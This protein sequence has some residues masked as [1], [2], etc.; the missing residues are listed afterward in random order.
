MAR[1]IL[2]TLGSLGDLHPI[3]ALALELRRRGHEAVV[4]TSE[5]Y[6]EKIHGLDL[7]FHPL[8]PDLLTSDATLIAEVMDGPRGSER[9][10]RKHLFP[11]VRAMYADLVTAVAG[12]DL[13]IASE[14]VF[15]API[16]AAKHAIPWVSYQ[17]APISIYSRYDPPVLPLP[18]ATRW[19]CRGGPVLARPVRAIAEIVSHSWWQPVRE[20]RQELGLPAGAHPLFAGKYSPRLNLALFSAELQGAQK[21][22]PA[23]TVQTGFPFYDESAAA[24]ALPPAV[25]AFLEAGDDPIVFTLGSAAVYLP[26]NFYEESVRAAQRLG[27]RALLLV[28]KNPPP[29]GL[30]RSLLAWDY[31]SFALIFPRAAAVVHQGGVGTTAQALR[32]GRPMVIVPFA[33]DQFDNA[34]RMTRRGVARTVPRAYYQSER[35]AAALRNLLENAPAHRTSAAIAARIRQERGV[36]QA[37]DAIESALLKL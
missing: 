6:R 37:V 9:L 16:V 36:E 18:V 32:A 8:R 11:V 10:F 29:T 7:D 31:L 30:P 5:C 23:A 27:R 21:D 25:S 20:L 17:L 33:H 22:W 12:A 15:A 24:H 14:L 28:G 26:G 2:A 1:I 3:I 13:L 34:A 4:A 35:V 19:L